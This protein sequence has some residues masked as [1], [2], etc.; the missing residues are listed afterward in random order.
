MHSKGALHLLLA[1]VPDQLGYAA[2]GDFLP[3]KPVGAANN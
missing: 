3:R 1:A 2:L